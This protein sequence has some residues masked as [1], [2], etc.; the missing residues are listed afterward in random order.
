VRSIVV[1][2]AITAVSSIIPDLLDVWYSVPEILL[3]V[4]GVFLGVISLAATAIG[5]VYTDV[6]R[7]ERAVYALT[8]L[9]LV[10]PSIAVSAVYDVLGLLGVPAGETVIPLNLSLR[11]VGLVVFAALLARNRPASRSREPATEPAES[12]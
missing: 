10:A 1:V 9:L 8:A 4:V 3:P 12:A 7:T 5:F 6:G 2:L 11:G